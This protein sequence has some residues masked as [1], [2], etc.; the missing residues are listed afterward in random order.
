MIE[1]IVKPRCPKC[2]R[3]QADWIEGTA[4]FTCPHCHVTF[5]LAGV[6]GIPL[7]SIL[8]KEDISAISK[9]N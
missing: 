4:Q 6:K 2:N 9:V 5:L 1:R 7:A 3:A 8:T